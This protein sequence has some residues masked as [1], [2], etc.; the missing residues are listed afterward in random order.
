MLQKYGLFLAEIKNLNSYKS[1]MSCIF[2]EQSQIEVLMTFAP[3]MHSYLSGLVSF[4]GDQA[5]ALEIMT[6]SERSAQP[7]TPKGQP[8]S[9][10]SIF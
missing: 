2:L 1:S 3:Y 8:L 10:I 7:Q 5:E 6:H 9:S 4:L